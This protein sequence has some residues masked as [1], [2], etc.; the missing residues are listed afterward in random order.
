MRDILHRPSCLYTVISTSL[1][2][3]REKLQQLA[4]PPYLTAENKL[5]GHRMRCNVEAGWNCFQGDPATMDVWDFTPERS[6]VLG[7]LTAKDSVSLFEQTAATVKMD[8]VIVAQLN[9]HGWI[10]CLKNTNPSVL[11]SHI[12]SS[13]QR[14]KCFRGEVIDTVSFF[15]SFLLWKMSREHVVCWLHCVGLLCIALHVLL[16]KMLFSLNVL[17]KHM[18]PIL[19]QS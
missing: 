15:I 2:G 19:T 16:G 9:G 14:L 12:S 5:I 13:S 3:S 4:Q 10:R 7:A 11:V 18:L 8:G 1:T 17:S 6:L